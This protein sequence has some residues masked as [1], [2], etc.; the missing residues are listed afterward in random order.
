MLGKISTMIVFVIMG[1]VF[2]HC[3]SVKADLPE[4]KCHLNFDL[5]SWSIFYKSGKG[6]GVITCDNGQSANVRI[7][8]KG[9]GITFGKSKIVG[10]QGTFSK[11]H[12]IEELF[13][14]YATSEA[15][16]GASGS[17][18]AQAMWKGDVGL[19]LSGTGKGWNLGFDFGN[20]KITRR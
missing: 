4:T 2:F 7:K 12:D 18:V 13:G 20:F 14:N 1:L 17:A 10:G 11:V 5:K 6:S 8:T 3:S 19:T 15:H 16:A 9:G